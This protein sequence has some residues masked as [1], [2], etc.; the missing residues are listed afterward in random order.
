MYVLP[1]HSASVLQLDKRL[2]RVKGKVVVV[3]QV[4][5]EVVAVAVAALVAVV[6]AVVVLAAALVE[7]VL[8]ER[9]SVITWVSGFR[10]RT[11]STTRIFRLP[12]GR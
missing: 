8:A 10:C 3:D 5:Q 1:R 9:A 11:C 2:R 4:A 6:V 7:V 12:M